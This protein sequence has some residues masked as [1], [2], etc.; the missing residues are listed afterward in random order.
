LSR[1]FQI[2]ALALVL[3]AGVL[4]LAH[5]IDL[6]IADLGR[7][8]KN[9]E[10]ILSEHRVPGTNLYS[11][12][13]PDFPFVNHHW[14]SGVLFYLVERAAGF[15]GL[16][17]FFIA[18]TLVTFLLGFLLGSSSSSFATAAFV[19]LPLI[20][21]LATR[22]EIR[23][24]AFSY[25]LATLFLCILGR[26]AEREGRG[27]SSGVPEGAPPRGRALLLLPALEV[28]WVN[29][30]I[31]FFLGPFL[32]GLFLIEALVRA[33]R[34]GASRAAGGAAPRWSR[35][36][37]L[38]IALVATSA[39]AL[40]NPA[41]LRGALYPLA[42]FG[43]YGQVVFENQP[44]LWVE[45]NFSFPAGLYF[46]IGFALLVV[47]WAYAAW[48]RKGRVSIALLLLSVFIS[49]LG[50]Q[51][52]RN[53]GLFAFLALPITSAN[54]AGAATS[55]RKA[56][57]GRLTS[58]PR[59]SPSFLF[60]ALLLWGTLLVLARPSFWEG[61]GPVRLGLQRGTPDAARFFTERG[62]AGPIFNNYDIGAY[63][64]YYLYPR[65]RVF[66]D[67]RP[68]A[69]PGA[70]FTDTYARIQEGEE[71]WRHALREYRFESLVVTRRTFS[72]PA[73]AF[74]EARARDP[75]WAA[76]YADSRIVIFVRRDGPYGEVVRD[77]EV[78]LAEFPRGR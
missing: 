40:I 11:Y 78:C 18:L 8:L 51:A 19:S 23:P 48:A 58:A 53:F 24:E 54:L 4:L 7:H 6:T 26:D 37:R 55:A 63:L 25:L 35:P 28:L 12:T 5:P 74:L 32:I 56:M 21:V 70:F 61:R 68:E 77:Y 9:G 75:L 39:A 10:I 60:A 31:Y 41:G 62:L 50:W 69:Y 16:H 72:V 43:N 71:G 29:L 22:P 27:A 1:G 36:R 2:A 52:I 34:E 66:V 33:R 73:R 17:A 47:S 38:G 67:N 15:V 57:A 65:E 14:G 3:G 76:V 44:L 64:I 42:I 13:Y 30:H 46:K 59:R 49:A 20:P 45:A